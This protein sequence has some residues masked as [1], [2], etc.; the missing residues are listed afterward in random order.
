MIAHDGFTLCDLV[1]YNFKV[2]KA[3]TIKLIQILW[4]VESRQLMFLVTC[5]AYSIMMQ[6]GKVAKM[7]AMTILAG[8]VVSKVNVTSHL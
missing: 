4:N 7:E 2:I 8:I 6:T 5:W 3:N 1:S